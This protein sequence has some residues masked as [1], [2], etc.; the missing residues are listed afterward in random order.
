MSNASGARARQRRADRLRDAAP[1]GVAAEQRRLDQR[2]V[3]DRARDAL[4]GLLA[5]AAHA[6][7]ADPPRALAVAR[8]SAARASRSIASSASAKR[9]S[10]R[11]A[12]AAR[13]A[14]H[15]DH[16]V[17]GRELAVDADAVEGLRAPRRRAARRRCSALSTASVCTKQSIVAKRGEIIPAPLHCAE[18][19]TSPTASTSVGC[20]S[21]ASVV[22]IAVAKPRGIGVERRRPAPGTRAAIRSPGSSTP[23][24]PVEATA[25][26]R[27]SQAERARRPP[28]GRAPPRRCRPRRSRRSRCRS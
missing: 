9:S 24:T 25:T 5:A 20:L 23:I 21:S 18:R 11:P 13:A 17:V 3:G 22:R 26:W 16:G 15:Q 10:R 19:R 6:H 27:G 2:R 4:G 28:P 12:H 7:A 14:R 8:R 1:V